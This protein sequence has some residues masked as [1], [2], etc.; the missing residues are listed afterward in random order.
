MKLLCDEM[1]AR[2]GRWLRAAGYDTLVAAPGSDDRHLLRT[3]IADGRVLLTRDRAL[4][5][6]TG[7]GRHVVVLQADGVP[8]QAREVA[9]RLAIDWL[10]QPFTRC[11]VDNAVLRAANARETEAAPA[12]ARALGGPYFAC[13]GCGRLYWEGSHHRR[14]RDRLESWRRSSGA[15]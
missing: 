7:A 4:A 10:R 5:A 12:L 9:R 3:A 1:L 13:P 11:V 14:M 2:L 8:A 6:R 15:P